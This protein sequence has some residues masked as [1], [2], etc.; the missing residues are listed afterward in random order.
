MSVPLLISGLLCAADNYVLQ[1]ELLSGTLF[2]AG[3]STIPMV[4]FGIR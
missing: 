2:M 1:A 4:W 3:F